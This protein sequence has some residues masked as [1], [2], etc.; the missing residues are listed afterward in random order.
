[1]TLTLKDYIFSVS[2][3]LAALSVVLFFS[4]VTVGRV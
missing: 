2:I 3:S 1:M 4:M